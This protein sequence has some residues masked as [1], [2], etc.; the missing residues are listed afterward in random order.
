MK[1]EIKEIPCEEV[2][3]RDIDVVEGEVKLEGEGRQFICS[4][5][6]PLELGSL[7]CPPQSQKYP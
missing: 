1:C 4:L 3:K 6:E 2:I 5:N 7:A